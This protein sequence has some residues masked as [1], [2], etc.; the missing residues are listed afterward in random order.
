MD[1]DITA[2]EDIATTIRELMHGVRGVQAVY[3]FGSRAAASNTPASDV[4]L[5]I[6]FDH[7]PDLQE[8]VRLQHQLEDGVE[9]KVDLIDLGSAGAFLALDAIRGHRLLCRDEDAC[10]EF[11]LYVLRRA[12]DLE[13][14]ERARRGMLLES[15]P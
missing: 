13:P 6:L 3:L 14:F 8:I 15:T 9:K 7:A 1:A 5:A 11:E 4:D 2:S 10:D 12:G